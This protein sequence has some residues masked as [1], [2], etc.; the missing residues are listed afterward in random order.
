[1]SRAFAKIVL[2]GI[3]SFWKTTNICRANK[4]TPKTMDCPQNVRF[5]VAK[6]I[7]NIWDMAFTVLFVLTIVTSTE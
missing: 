2:N 4:T 7:P 6:Q 5:V 3:A 1:M